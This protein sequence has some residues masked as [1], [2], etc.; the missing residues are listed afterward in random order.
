VVK[1]VAAL[2]ASLTL[3]TFDSAN[4]LVGLVDTENEFPYVVR[5]Y[6]SIGSCTG[7]VSNDGLV[8]TAAHC[9]WDQEKGWANNIRVRY[10]D[11]NGIDQIVD[12]AR[13]FVSKKYQEA[14]YWIFSKSVPYDIAFIVTKTPVQTLGYA[15][16]IDEL[17]TIPPGTTTY[18]G[19][20]EDVSPILSNFSGVWTDSLKKELSKVL[21]NEVGDLHH[22]NVLVVGYGFYFCPDD[23][24]E[25]QKNCSYDGKR[26]YTRMLQSSE[27]FGDSVSAPWVWCSSTTDYAGVSSKPINP[28]QH[29]DS[30]GPWFIRTHDGRW[31]FVGYTSGGGTVDECASSMFT[32]YESL[33]EASAWKH[34]NVVDNVVRTKK[35]KSLQVQR[36]MKEFFDSWSST[37]NM[38]A[39]GRLK[40]F[41]MNQTVLQGKEY[42]FPELY[43]EKE[44]FAKRWPTRSYR[45]RLNS[46]RVAFDPKEPDSSCVATMI[47]DWEV[48]NSETNASKTGTAEYTF[49]LSIQS[50]SFGYETSGQ[51][52]LVAREYSR[53]LSRN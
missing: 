9:V 6:S 41:Y 39:L 50:L 15:H 20:G 48:Q 34:N 12:A 49:D 30:G 2:L 22:A 19:H 25:D 18:G 13:T 40:W 7:I 38:E 17:F 32:N 5:V 53:V 8:S 11:E 1:Y 36:F 35:W 31:I 10:A 33:L 47:V 27:F 3:I 51:S 4:A 14:G 46:L 23:N 43:R 24:R 26:R 29:G 28:V 37:N 16:W 42:K 44:G 45:P 52:V 21:A